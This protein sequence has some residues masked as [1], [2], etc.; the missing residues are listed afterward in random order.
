[1]ILSCSSASAGSAW[2]APAGTMT[3]A[4]AAAATIVFLKRDMVLSLRS[5]GEAFAT[6]TR[7]AGAQDS[8]RELAPHAPLRPIPGVS[9]A[10]RDRSLMWLRKRY[11]RSEGS[12]LAY[13]YPLLGLFWTML[14]FFLWI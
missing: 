14:W 8:R 4:A 1:M 6:A 7:R 12:V 3:A 9:R 5:G 2:V 10:T 11:K 13:D